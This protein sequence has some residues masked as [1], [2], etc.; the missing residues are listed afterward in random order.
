MLQILSC[1]KIGSSYF[2]IAD[3]TKKCYTDVFFSYGYLIILPLLLIFMLGVPYF[4]YKILTKNKNKLLVHD[5]RVKYGY[6]YKEYR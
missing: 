4:L 5:I 2:I 6:I 3:M 1:R